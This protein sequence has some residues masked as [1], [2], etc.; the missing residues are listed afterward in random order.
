MG[1]LYLSRELE[2]VPGYSDVGPEPLVISLDVFRDQLTQ[3]RGE[4]KAVLT[5][6]GFVAGIGNAYADEILWQARLHP[7]RK[8]GKLDA[9]EVER[10]YVAIRSTLQEAIDKVRTEMKDNI[11]LK[12]REFMAVHNKTGEPCPRCGNSISLVGAN[13]RITNFC[14]TCQPGDYS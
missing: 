10:L 13:D 8:T 9:G 12:P 2:A 4:I 11:H 6:G 3:Q 7:H 5:R 1:Q 14:R